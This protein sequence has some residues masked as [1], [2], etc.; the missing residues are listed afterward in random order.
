MSAFSDLRKAYVCAVEKIR[1]EPVGD[2][3]RHY[4][5][6]TRYFSDLNA[7]MSTL[8][9]P[10]GVLPCYIGMLISEFSRIG[11]FILYHS[12]WPDSRILH[13]RR[14]PAQNVLLAL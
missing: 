13:I 3:S 12:L 1:F 7:Y 5:C 14:K 2:P 11:H 4:S 9:E 6:E 8:R 10:A